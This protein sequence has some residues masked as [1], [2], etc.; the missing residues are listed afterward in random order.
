MR[1]RHASRCLLACAVALLGAPAAA[2]A[3]SF[4]VTTTADAGDGSLRAAIAGANAAAGADEVTFAESVTGAIRLQSA[5]P[6]VISEVSIAGPG[7]DVLAVTRA[8]DAPDFRIF[9]LAGTADAHISGLTIRGGRVAESSSKGGG[10]MVGEGGVLVLAGTVVRDNAAQSI[11]EGSNASGGGVYASRA[12]LTILDSTIT[13]NTASVSNVGRAIT[14]VGGG[15]VTLANG[16]AL[17]VRRSTISANRAVIDGTERDGEAFGGGASVSGF[18]TSVVFESVTFA[19]NEVAAPMRR[20]SVDHDVCGTRVAAEHDHRRP[21]RG[22]RLQGENGTFTSAGHNLTERHVL[23][24]R[25]DRGS[26]G[27]RSVARP[28]VRQRR[29]DADACAARGQPGPGPRQLR[30]S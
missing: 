27:R 16:G 10:I 6:D 20:R 21:D 12:S 30:G 8:T 19:G 18:S 15:G 25:R 7:A 2:G 23:R 11:P 22:R 17:V 9:T 1:R 3:A 24:P 26:R 29:A 4:P 14:G 28:A 13:G 5:L